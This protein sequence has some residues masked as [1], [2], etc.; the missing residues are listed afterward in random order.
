MAEPSWR[1][2]GSG[3]GRNGDWFRIRRDGFFIAEVRTS[4]ELG[5][6]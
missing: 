1:R 4:A 6:S 2:S 5:G 3:T